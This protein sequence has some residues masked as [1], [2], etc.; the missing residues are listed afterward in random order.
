MKTIYSLF[1]FLIPVQLLA[2]EN[3]YWWDEVFSWPILKN[4]TCSTNT[5]GDYSFYNDLNT[6]IPRGG[7]LPLQNSP[8]KVIPININM[9]IGYE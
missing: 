8:I 3:P 1:L 5:S 4:S 6:W 9:T 7:S 2:Q